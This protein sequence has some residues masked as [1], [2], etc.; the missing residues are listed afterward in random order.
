MK[1]TTIYYPR[2]QFIALGVAG[3]TGTILA[4]CGGMNEDPR[5]PV[6]Y[7]L[8]APAPNWGGDII[9]ATPACD[10]GD[11]DPTLTFIEGPYY[12]PTTPNKVSFLDDGVGGSTL[13]LSGQ[14]MT[15]ACQPIAGAVL[16][17]WHCDAA[18]NYD[19][20]GFTLRG[21]QFTD[22]NGR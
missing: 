17:I 4:A 7:P 1:K 13:L 3:V 20:D 2:R 12:R 5:T 15:T 6:S 10:D 22:A 19:N 14:V 18:G 11:E 8:G 16:D 9:A 21:H